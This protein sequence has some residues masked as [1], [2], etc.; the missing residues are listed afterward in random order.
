MKVT[1]C[2]QM[3]GRKYVIE[4]QT[5]PAYFC[6]ECLEFIAEDTA[7]YEQELRDTRGY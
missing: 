6:E 1:V 2:C 3:C 7:K 5:L 4:E